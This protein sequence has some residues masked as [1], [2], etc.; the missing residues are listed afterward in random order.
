M[1]KIILDFGS[2]NTCKN[3]KNYIKR[4]LDELKSI[5]NR[6]HEII[7]KWQLFERAGD[8]VP[9]LHDLFDY[10]YWYAKDL[11]YST[12]SS[13]FDYSSL[14]FLLE[15]SIPFVKIANN[16]SLDYLIGEIPRKIPIY[17]SSSSSYFYVE[18]QQKLTYND[19]IMA[20]VSEYPAEVKSYHFN[21]E[22]W[23]LRN[24]SD[25]TTGF[26]LFKIHKPSIIEW[27][28]GLSDS[29]GLDAG[30]FMKTPEKLMEI[31]KG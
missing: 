26:E 8:N 4:M 10:A 25:H 21:F 11:G 6:K 30:E 31:M 3:D 24:I 23:H 13:V 17:I 18:L 12:T 28:Y 16:R 2:G 7:V 27:H 14:K 29:T 1:A 20:C 22:Y 15:Y 9:L 19:I 5:D